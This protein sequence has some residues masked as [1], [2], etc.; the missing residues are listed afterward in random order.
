MV[1]LITVNDGTAATSSP[2]LVLGYETARRGRN[3]FH[4]I[5]GGGNAVSLIPADPRS[6]T[7]RLYYPDEADAAAAVELHGRGETLTI[8]ETDIATLDMEYALDGNVG[9][10]LDTET[11]D[12]WVVSV[13]YREIL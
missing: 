6:G 12:D 1:T 13:D 3:L 9:Y 8:T 11:L 10:A 7:L 4:E 5:L 2:T